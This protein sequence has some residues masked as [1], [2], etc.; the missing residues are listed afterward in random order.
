[1][2]AR[3][4]LFLVLSILGLLLW[5]VAFLFGFSYTSAGEWY[6]GLAVTL[7][8]VALMGWC[9]YMINKTNGERK[10]SSRYAQKACFVLYVVIALLSVWYVCHFIKVSTN[11]MRSIQASVEE[12]M[13]EIKR[14]F[15]SGAEERGSYEEWVVEQEAGYQA[16]LEG[17]GVASGTIETEVTTLDDAIMNNSDFEDLK[18]NVENFVSGCE[19]NIVT[20]NYLG[21]Q[22]Y[23]SQLDDKKDEYKNKIE[24]ISAGSKVTEAEPFMCIY[25]SNDKELGKPLLELSAKDFSV[26]SIVLVIVLQFMILLGYFSG[27]E[28][29]GRGPRKWTDDKPAP[30]TKKERTRKKEIEID[31]DESI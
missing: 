31:E 23:L 28:K 26:L 18:T 20:W 4:I 5:A 27:K 21:V 7:L 13:T 16:Q 10:A 29:S 6:V 11:D 30:E 12:Q 2:E 9:V 8:G 19:K 1:M 25:K 22:K 14:I 15:L 24:E 17:D 3:K